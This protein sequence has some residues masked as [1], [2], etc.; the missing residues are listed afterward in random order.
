MRH[1]RGD[2][3]DTKTQVPENNTELVCMC[4]SRRG[5]IHLFSLKTSLENKDK[6]SVR[7]ILNLRTSTYENADHMTAHLSRVGLGL[8]RREV[9]L[10][11]VK[12][13]ME[14]RVGAETEPELNNRNYCRMRCVQRRARHK[15][16]NA[17]W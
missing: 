8:C 6:F 11:F 15:E 3:I 12:K 17:V 2:D 13:K 9:G 16:S 7:T 10:Y 5:F 14:K 4:V 1:I